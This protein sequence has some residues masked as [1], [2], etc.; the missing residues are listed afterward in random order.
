LKARVIEATR[1]AR[2]DDEGVRLVVH[3]LTDADVSLGYRTVD[4]A[5][6]ATNLEARAAVQ[7]EWAALRDA[8]IQALVGQEWQF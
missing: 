8:T 5:A 3:F 6:G 7:S 4:I 1:H 2:D